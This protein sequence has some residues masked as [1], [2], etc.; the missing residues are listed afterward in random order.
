MSGIQGQDIGDV[1]FNQDGDAMGRYSVYQYQ[2]VENIQDPKGRTACG[3]Q[4]GPKG[5][6]AWGDIA[7]TSTSTERT[8]RTLKVEQHVYNSLDPKV[9]IGCVEQPGS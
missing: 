4:Q 7:S 5:R 3:E 1:K 6:T 8:A 9:R 2:H